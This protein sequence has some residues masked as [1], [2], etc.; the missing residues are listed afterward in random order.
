MSVTRT[1]GQKTLQ[2]DAPLDDN[3]AVPELFPSF[4][5]PLGEVC[6]LQPVDS[7]LSSDRV[8]YSFC[9]VTGPFDGC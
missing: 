3:L 9:T 5:S 1:A 2:R 8:D 4:Y 7:T 6:A